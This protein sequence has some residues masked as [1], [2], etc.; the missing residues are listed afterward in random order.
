MTEFQ[1]HVDVNGST[2]NLRWDEQRVDVDTLQR[3]VSLAADD[4]LVEFA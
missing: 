2:G 3:A 4:V 1:V